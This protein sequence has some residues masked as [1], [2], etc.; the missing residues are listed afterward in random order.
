MKWSYHLVPHW[1]PLAWLA[2]WRRGHDRVDVALGPQVETHEH[3]FGEA[4]WEGDFA[5]GRLCDTDLVFGSGGCIADGEC[6]FVSP[7]STVDRLQSLEHDGRI[8]VSNS[9]ACLLA[10]AKANVDPNYTRYYRE[11]KSIIHGLGAYRRELATTAGPVRLTYYNNLRWREGRLEEIPKRRTRRDFSTFER[12]RD[13]LES[14]LCRLADNMRDSRRTHPLQM[15][16]TVSTGFD[17]PTVA[18]LARRAGLRQTLSFDKARSMEDDCGAGIAEQLGLQPLVAQRDLWR[19]RPLSEV[20]FL[21]ADAKGEDV[22]FASAEEHLRGKLVLTGFGA[23]RVWKPGNRPNDEFRRGDQSGLSLTEYRLWCGFIHCPVAGIGSTQTADLYAML[24]SAEMAPWRTGEAYNKPFC[25]RV[26][27]EAGVPRG[28]FGVTKKA[29]SV[30]FFRS[31]SFLT[32]ASEADY[33]KWIASLAASRHKS[34]L[35]RIQ[36]GLERG[37]RTGVSTSARLVQATARTVSASLPVPWLSRAGRSQRL[38]T[39]AQY[40]PRFQHL[41]PWALERAKERYRQGSLVAGL[42]GRFTES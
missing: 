28:M 2:S 35:S 41:F 16:A 36:T 40:D 10:A 13:F 42:I 32:S 6:V 7:A 29:A 9:L 34:P 20:P 1:P 25:R 18:A 21:A 37:L 24:Q 33:L 4:V 23:S 11:F 38:A 30:L 22:Y 39:L 27:E 15:I 12:Y 8:Y 5:E 31:E 14:S 17:S 3:W 19:Q 26:L